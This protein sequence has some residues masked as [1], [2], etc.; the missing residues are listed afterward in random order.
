VSEISRQS[1]GDI[2]GRGI[3][4]AVFLLGLGLLIAVFVWTYYLFSG[5]VPQVSPTHNLAANSPSLGESVVWL[6][7]KMGFLFIMGYLASL[8]AT[9]GIELYRTSREAGGR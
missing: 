5:A 9:K 4:V 7:I 3:G 6:L 8:I 2:L 1:T